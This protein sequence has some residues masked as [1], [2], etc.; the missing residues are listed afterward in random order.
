MI[1]KKGKSKEVEEIR[2]KKK[3]SKRKEMGEKK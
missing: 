2:D 1:E 3:K